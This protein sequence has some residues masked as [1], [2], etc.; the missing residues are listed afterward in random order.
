MI[1]KI[2]AKNAGKFWLSMIPVVIVGVMAPL[3]SYIM[4][5]LIDSKS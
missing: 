1:K 5:L 3:R 4:Q 2:V